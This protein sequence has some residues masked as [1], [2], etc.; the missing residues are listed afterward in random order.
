MTQ[1]IQYNSTEFLA[2]IY[3]FPWRAEGKTEIHVHHTWR[4]NHSQ[5]RGLSSI[6]SMRNYHVYEKGWSD[7]AQ[8]VSIGPDGSIWTGRDWNRTP[9]SAFGFNHA[10][11]F[12]IETIGDFDHGKDELKGAQYDALL[13]VVAGIQDL[14]GLPLWWSIKFHNQMSGKTCPGS[15]ISR[16]KFIIDVRSKLAELRS[17]QDAPILNEPVFEGLS[18]DGPQIKPLPFADETAGEMGHDAALEDYFSREENQILEVENVF[19]EVENYQKTNESLALESSQSSS[20][21]ELARNVTD[22]KAPS[23]PVLEAVRVLHEAE[24]Y[25]TA[26]SKN[27]QAALDTDILL[28][29]LGRAVQSPNADKFYMPSLPNEA[30]INE[31]HKESLDVFKLIGA[32]ILQRIEGQL[33]SLVCG[34]ADED[35][36]DRD[37]I[38]GAIGLS[39][40]AAKV[41]ITAW[42]ASIGF[43]AV[44]AGIAGALILRRFVRPAIEEGH[45]TIC[46]VWGEKVAAD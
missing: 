1:F 27:D 2:A 23:R 33:Y 15:A 6:E 21:Y 18:V 9:V 24:D 41:M 4:P 38:I 32:R 13:T 26:I 39:E 10:G 11:V 36:A 7:I 42:L 28:S 20:F 40:T 3:E 12:M 45:K 44:V 17:S 5:Y 37:K 16:S 8:H 25:V 29:A 31:V 30:A 22:D 34:D 35:K 46:E 43:T 14:F 19:Q